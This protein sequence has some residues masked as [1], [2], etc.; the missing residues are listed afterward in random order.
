[1]SCVMLTLSVDVTHK[2][3]KRD[4]AG[5]RPG[6]RERES[7]T[8]NPLPE[9][10]TATLPEVTQLAGRKISTAEATDWH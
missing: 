5:R 2:E 8:Y 3:V 6:E 1:M 4:T 7:N 9:T 10:H